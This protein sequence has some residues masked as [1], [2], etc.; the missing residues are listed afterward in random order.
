MKDSLSVRLNRRQV[1]GLLGVG[2]GTISIDAVAVRTR[3][4][5]DTGFAA[6]AAAHPL[7]RLQQAS[8]GAAQAQQQVLAKTDA[9]RVYLQG[10]M[11]ARGSGA[12]TSGP[13]SSSLSGLG[14]DRVNW[15]AGVQIVFPNLFDV[16]SLR[17]RRAEAAA[18]TRAESAR[19]DETLLAVTAQQQ[20]AVATAAAARAIAANTPLQLAAARQ[21]ETQIRARYDAGLATL[22]ELADAQSLLAQAEMQDR[23]ARIDVWRAL[24]AQA[25]A[26]GSL[27]PFLTLLRP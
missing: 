27:S 16:A 15:A 24:L 6:P 19:Y 1:I 5:A 9:P 7:A 18:T 3:L 11:M 13:S 8:F 12:E 20:A 10:S 21:S 2:A 14:L 23:A 25:V 17:A 26:G 4:P 22:G